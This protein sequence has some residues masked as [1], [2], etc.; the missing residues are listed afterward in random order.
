MTDATRPELMEWAEYYCP[1]CYI[2]AVRLHRIGKEY[3]ERVTVRSRF[4]PL[5]LLR[6]GGPPRPLLEQEWWL[7]AIQEPAAVFAPY[8]VEDWPTTTLP[9]FDAAWAA[10]RQGH[11]VGMDY[12]LR[13]RRAFFGEGRNIGR[14]DVLLDIAREA[15]LDMPR[16][17]RDVASPEARAAV[18]E[19]SRIGREEFR[20]RGTPTL[21]LADGTHLDL[22]ITFPRIRAHRIVG[23]PPLECVG[24]TCS[25]SMRALFER[26]LAGHET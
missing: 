3:E 22:P 20:V 11:A 18:L 10:F 2:A 17:Q 6:P 21:T 14:P 25:D 1:W 19:E 7:A 8:P 16:F 26:A 4:F 24:E 13:V 5:D 12:D 15:A 23:M 9:A